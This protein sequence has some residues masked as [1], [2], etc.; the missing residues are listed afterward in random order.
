VSNASGSAAQPLVTP[1]G[2]TPPHSMV[3]QTEN[4]STQGSLRALDAEKPKRGVG[5]IVGLIAGLTFLG[6]GGYYAYTFL[7]SHKQP[8][9][10]SKTIAK[11]AVNAA[12]T[13]PKET[14]VA[15]VPP[16]PIEEKPK[17]EEKP[18]EAEI[19]QLLEWAKRTAEGGRIIA[20]PGDNLK[21]LLDRIEKA[22]PGNPD[23][24]QLRARTSAILGRRGVLA[25][26][27]QRLEEAEDAF[28]ALVVLKPDDDWSKGRLARTL[29]VRADRSL[30]HKRYTAAIADANQAL[31]LLP[32]DVM[33]RTALAESFLAL[34]KHEQAAEEFGRVLE[35]RPA[36]KRAKIGRAAALAPPPKKPAKPGPKKKK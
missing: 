1:P 26:K 25:L 2:L 29:A 16:S 20:P 5:G 3:A 8:V 34:G 30:E 7:E 24:A 22:S 27:K 28:R 36:D 10:A 6:G 31:E 23:A 32:D 13:P 17:V 14:P 19:A 4:A 15:A 18:S 33:A 12:K 11:T 35:L 21:E 9:A